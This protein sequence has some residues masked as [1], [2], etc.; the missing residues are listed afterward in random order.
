MKGC[1]LNGP[2]LLQNLVVPPRGAGGARPGD[3]DTKDKS[4]PSSELCIAA[5]VPPETW[6]LPRPSS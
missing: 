2:I 5:Q 4:V 6:P 1:A 3:G